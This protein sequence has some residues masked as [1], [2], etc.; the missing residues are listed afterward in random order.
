MTTNFFHPSLLLLFLHPGSEIR[1]EYPGSAT[2]LLKLRNRQNYRQPIKNVECMALE[3]SLN[4]R[5]F[6]ILE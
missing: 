5:G 1:D 2:L 6:V 4:I 3:A